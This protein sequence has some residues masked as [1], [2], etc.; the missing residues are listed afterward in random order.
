MADKPIPADAVAASAEEVKQDA[1][2]TDAQLMLAE[3][4][5]TNALLE[6]IAKAMETQSNAQPPI[7]TGSARG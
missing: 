1:P 3:V 6:R 5:R 4:K 2:L 7:Q